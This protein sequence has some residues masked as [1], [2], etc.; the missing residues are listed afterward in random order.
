MADELANIGLCLRTYLRESNVLISVD[1]L[2]SANNILLDL[3]KDRTRN[4]P[5]YSNMVIIYVGR[6]GQGDIGL[7]QQQER[8]DICCYGV[9]A[10]QA[11]KIWRAVDFYL[12]PL[13]VRRKT[14]FTR[15][16][17]QVNS[18]LREGGPLRLTDPDAADWPYTIASYIVNYNGEARP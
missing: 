5:P 3:P 11:A 8:V 16:N 9:N 10:N 7:G 12:N 6:G 4:V 2:G 1:Y 15:D 18:I 13:G 14:S 17:C